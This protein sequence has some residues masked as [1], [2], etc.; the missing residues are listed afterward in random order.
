[1][2]IVYVR[3][4]GEARAGCCSESLPQKAADAQLFAE[5][6][7]FFMVLELNGYAVLLTGL[8]CSGKTTIA[9]TVG[10]LLIR[11]GFQAQII[12]GDL[13][14]QSVSKDLGFSKQD[15]HRNMER[16]AEMAELLTCD[17]KVVLIA[18][19]APYEI[20]RSHLRERIQKYIEVHVDCSLE[21]CIQRDVKGLYAKAIRGEIRN[22][23]GVNDPYESPLCP[24]LVL[25]TDQ[26]DI[27]TCADILLK[28][29]LKR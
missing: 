12:D 1:V 19:C 4:R 24:D 27:F 17:G 14:R 9:G 7:S 29:L 11:Q 22:F 6:I 26:D 2:G 25:H 28:L 23:T 5:A 8:P 3:P 13:V 20:S 10:E 16:I 21:V 15:R 18:V